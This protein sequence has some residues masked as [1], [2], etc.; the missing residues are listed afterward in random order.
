MNKRD[1]L[2]FS[3][4]VGVAA[5]YAPSVS[6]QDRSS[7]TD[8]LKNMTGDAQAISVDERMARVAKA[9]KLMQ[10]SGID[11]LLLESGS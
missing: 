9:Q 6:A 10:E 2:K 3:G 4:A 7:S 11:A 1:F 8:G 5:A